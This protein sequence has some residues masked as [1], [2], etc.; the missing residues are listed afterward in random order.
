VSQPGLGAH[1]VVIETPAHE[2]SLQDLNIEAVTR[3]L[4][5]WR[6]RIADLKRDQRFA[7]ALAFKNHGRLASARLDHAHSQIVAYPFVPPLLDAEVQ[8]AKAHYAR[9]GRGLLAD[10][11]A[12]ETRSGSRLIIDAPAVAIAPYASRVPFHVIITP[13]AA[14]PR[15]EEASDESLASV[16]GVLKDVL[17]R[18][19][20][21][22]E[23]PAYNL[24]LHTTPFRESADGFQWWLEILPRINRIGGQEWGS[25]IAR[26]PVFPEDAAVALR[27]AQPV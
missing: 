21:A 3:V 15:F 19:D 22:L 16:A 5:A 1:E 20:R 13:R 12:L 8:L 11:V 2:P 6:S 14:E 23:Q 26:N 17:P 10:I 25:G 7:C 24:M 27:R 9:T 4:T 18:I